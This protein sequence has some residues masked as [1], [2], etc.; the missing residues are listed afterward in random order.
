MFGLRVDVNS[1]FYL[2]PYRESTVRCAA[3]IYPA[4]QRY[5]GRMYG[6][7]TCGLSRPSVSS[8]QRTAHNI[9]LCF[10]IT[11]MTVSRDTGSHCTVAVSMLIDNMI[12]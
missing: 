3:Y 5:V 1:L 12:L 8:H 2:R 6:S 10:A 4:L 9:S 7:L 11:V